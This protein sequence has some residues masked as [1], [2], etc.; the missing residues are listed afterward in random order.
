M[1]LLRSKEQNLTAKEND[2]LVLRQRDRGNYVTERYL[3]NLKKYNNNEIKGAIQYQRII[4]GYSFPVNVINFEDA[5]KNVL[6]IKE[7]LGRRKSIHKYLDW[8]RG[9]VQF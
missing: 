6:R 4:Q 7:L 9:G 2:S 5:R 8:V 3:E 1:K